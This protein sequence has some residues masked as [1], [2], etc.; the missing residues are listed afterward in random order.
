MTRPLTTAKVARLLSAVAAV[1]F[2]FSL[3]AL[4]ILRERQRHELPRL[5]L[6]PPFRFTDQSG[7][8]FGRGDLDGKPWVVDFVFTS[9][10]EVCPRMTEEMARLQTWLRNRALLGR[11]HLV[12]VSVD[13]ERD[14][15]DR[16]R[17]YAAR[18]HVDGAA[19]KLL[20]GDPKAI[21]DAA[22]RGFKI[23]VGRDAE[24]QDPFAILHGT[25]FVLVDRHDAIR[26]YYDPND[27]ASMAQLR[28]DVQ[29]LA[30]TDR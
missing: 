9:C 5:G 16:L 14:T 20:T 22:V 1:L 2:L 28:A 13:P 21:E 12:S 29:F 26:G 24:S 30:E 27:G 25:K 19:W 3:G 7:A 4:R 18:F 6:V 15:P 8:P 11:V 23:A 17:E 10:P